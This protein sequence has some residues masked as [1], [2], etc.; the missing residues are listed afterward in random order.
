MMMMMMLLLF[1][2]DDDFMM[3]RGC[4]CRR[5][6]R[7]QRGIFGCVLK[8]TSGSNNTLPPPHK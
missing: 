6:G 5:A 3:S 7:A 1:V 4:S 2:V 8:L